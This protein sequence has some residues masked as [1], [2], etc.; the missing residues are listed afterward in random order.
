MMVKSQLFFCLFGFYIAGDSFLTFE[1][2]TMREENWALT[3]NGI[4]TDWTRSPGNQQDQPQ[5]ADIVAWPSNS[6]SGIFW[7]HFSWDQGS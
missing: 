4:G 3:E 6:A 7:T 2:F 1:T 5:R